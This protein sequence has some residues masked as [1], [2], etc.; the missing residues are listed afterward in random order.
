MF[1]ISFAKLVVL[2]IVALIVLGPEKLSS[3]ARFAGVMV[4]RMRRFSENVKME[5]NQQLSETGL[6][7]LKQTIQETTQD[8][9]EGLQNALID[10][11]NSLQEAQEAYQQE[12]DKTAKLEE[13]LST[14][15]AESSVTEEVQA[16]SDKAEIIDDIDEHIPTQ[17]D[18]PLFDEDYGSK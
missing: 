5:M 3:V 13:A 9:R 12:K 10:V 4:S 16:V 14:L 17:Q 7:D 11:Q 2:G 15:T 18:L 8:V 1:D 6:T